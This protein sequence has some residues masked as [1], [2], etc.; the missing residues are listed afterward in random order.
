M[1]EAILSIFLCS[2]IFVVTAQVLNSA[3]RIL[4]Q[5]RYKVA[6]QQGVQVAMTRIAGEL[7]EAKGISQIGTGVLELYKVDASLNRYSSLA[8]F[9]AQLTV[10]Y[11]LQNG[12][13]TR[14]VTPGGQVQVVAEEVYGFATSQ[15]PNQNVQ[16]SL[17]F[18]DPRQVQSYDLQVAVPSAW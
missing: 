4:R 10:R 14:L 8:N 9:N 11:Q 7:R 16:V 3:Y 6:A 2:V 18:R 12:R 17:T 5:E 1:A 13:L 15:L